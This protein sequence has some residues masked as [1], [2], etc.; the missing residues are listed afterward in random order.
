MAIASAF[1]LNGC[2]PA[3]QAPKDRANQ[4]DQKDGVLGDSERKVLNAGPAELKVNDADGN[5]LWSIAGESTRVGIDSENGSQAFLE[6]VAGQ[7]FE[8]GKAVSKFES[9]S[10]KADT[11]SRT[12]KL[13][14]RVTVQSLAV[15]ATLE[16]DEL[17]W[18]ADKELFVATGSVTVKRDDWSFGPTPKIY[19]R[20]DL[21][22]IGSS[23]SITK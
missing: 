11:N 4:S 2:G 3:A 8:N 16:A 6:K 14:E 17:E 12:F 22:A 21:S 15:K 13:L 23:E 5:L 9:Q 7:V 1:I 10:G 20:A 19:A 18:L